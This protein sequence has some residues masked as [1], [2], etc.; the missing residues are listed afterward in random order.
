MPTLSHCGPGP[1][2]GCELRH[3]CCP[4]L[5]LQMGR[6]SLAEVEAAG[7]WRRLMQQHRQQPR[8]QLLQRAWE[9][10]SQQQS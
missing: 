1:G 3:C 2:P 4:Q 8:E 6:V 10:A 7:L 5:Q 9:Q